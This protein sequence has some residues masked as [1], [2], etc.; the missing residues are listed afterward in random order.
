MKDQRV[1]LR[2][3]ASLVL[4]TFF[5]SGYFPIM[6]GTI[7]SLATIPLIL[8]FAFFNTSFYTLVLFIVLLTA[9]SCFE[10]HRIQEKNKVQDPGWIVI[11]EVI[12]MLITWLFVFPKTDWIHLA[13]IFISFR[14]FDI[15]K[16]FPANWVDKKIKNGAGTILDDVVSGIYAGLLLLCLNYFNLLI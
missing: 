13:V 14:V 2:D 12:G 3:K 4:L 15:I 5:G 9:I 16:I 10:A 8:L 7:G 11:D 1:P 6:P